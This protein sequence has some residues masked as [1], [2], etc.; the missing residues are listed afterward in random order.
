[1]FPSTVFTRTSFLRIFVLPTSLACASILLTVVCEARSGIVQVHFC[2]PEWK[3]R[4]IHLYSPDNNI[5]MYG[6]P[7]V[8]PHPPP[9]ALASVRLPPCARFRPLQH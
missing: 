5:S 4:L 1:M 6:L 3:P 7:Q 8:F 9:I 2:V